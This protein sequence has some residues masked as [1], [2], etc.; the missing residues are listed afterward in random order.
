MKIHFFV[1]P[2][3]IFCKFAPAFKKALKTNFDFGNKNL[4]FTNG[5]R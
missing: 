4:G 2:K 3:G 5:R 1:I